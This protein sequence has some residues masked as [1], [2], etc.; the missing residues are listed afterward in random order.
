[1]NLLRNRPYLLS[2]IAAVVV[3]TTGG[4]VAFLVVLLYLLGM[5]LSGPL[6]RALYQASTGKFAI[7]L[8]VGLFLLVFGLLARAVFHM[9]ARATAA[10]R[11]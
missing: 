7:A 4:V 1:M 3:A 9:A 2:R 8:S 6:N 10:T 11:T 5:T